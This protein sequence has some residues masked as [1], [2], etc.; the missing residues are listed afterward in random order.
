M[1]KHFSSQ[2]RLTRTERVK[3]LTG[4]TSRLIDEI[5]EVSIEI[6]LDRLFKEL[7]Q[8]AFDNK[9][10]VSKEMAGAIVARVR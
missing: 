10:K 3:T 1:K 5:V 2:V 8:R 7:G 6:D 9:S 4:F